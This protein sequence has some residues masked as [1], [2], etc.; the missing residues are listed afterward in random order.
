MGRFCDRIIKRGLVIR[1]RQ[2]RREG[3]GVYNLPGKLRDEER[4]G[5]EPLTRT[6]LTN[7][8]FSSRLGWIGS[9]VARDAMDEWPRAVGV[10][11][12]YVTATG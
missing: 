8:P 5:E 6:Q 12:D 2:T 10:M 4:R 7:A 11:T 1:L 9:C 3:A